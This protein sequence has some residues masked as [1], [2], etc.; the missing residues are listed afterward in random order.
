LPL[1][2]FL[3]NPLIVMFLVGGFIVIVLPSYFFLAL[4]LMGVQ[5]M[6]KRKKGRSLSPF[7]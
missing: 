2:A 6:T 5:T 4:W 3:Q 7:K 1:S